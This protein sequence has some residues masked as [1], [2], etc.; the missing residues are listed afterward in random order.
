MVRTEKSPA[1]RQVQ[2]AP[3]S[4][5]D[6][7][8]ILAEELAEHRLSRKF[9]PAVMREVR[10][11]VA[12]PGIEDASLED[13]THL[14]FVTVDNGPV[15]ARLT[16]DAP[17]EGYSRDL[18]QALYLEKTKRG[19]DLYYALVDAA[20][21]LNPSTSPAL[22]E[23]ALQ[24]TTTVYLPDA[25]VP[26]LPRELS[27]GVM[28]LNPDEDRRALVYKVSLDRYGN[29]LETQQLRARIHSRAQLTY[30]GVQDFF[31]QPAMS[32]LADQDFTR[33][34]ELMRAVG[35]VRSR[36]ARASSAAFE[37]NEVHVGWSA[38][39][40]S[41][42]ELSSSSELPVEDWNSQLSLLVNHEAGL[43][44]T[45]IYKQ[46]PAPRAFDV[47]KA[48][49]R[50][51]R[52]V[53]AHQL[54]PSVWEWPNGM[55]MAA[56]VQRLPRDEATARIRSVVERLVQRTNSAATFTTE[57]GLHFGTGMN[58][59]A[60][61]TAPMREIVGSVSQAQA[62]GE[63]IPAEV[64]ESVVAAANAAKKQ[65]GLV[66][67]HIRKVAQ[68]QLLEKDLNLPER[69]RPV[70]R[71]TVMD[72]KATKLIVRLDSPAVEVDVFRDNLKDGFVFGLGDAVDLKVTGYD[73]VTDRWTFSTNCPS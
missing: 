71:G 3:R 20:Y 53:A 18:D 54:D 42:F 32:E 15:A 30:S 45:G 28:S 34:L 6:A 14:P 23:E 48:R 43:K 26:M 66:E 68:D 24:R 69:Q 59:Y 5:W 8:H 70:R 35:Q 2:S 38:E 64:I 55:S 51:S 9:P 40:P 25:S 65:D 36:S 16:P 13:L 27:E 46:H 10:R 31:D 4:R 58:P 62:L 50:I 67:K 56:Y 63:E 29:V 60:R 73:D 57:P 7:Q 19:V 37:Q 1:R 61:V 39:N 12:D 11:I 44:G 47:Q 72:V 52:L 41:R 22:F 33:S 21:Y 17:A 49:Q